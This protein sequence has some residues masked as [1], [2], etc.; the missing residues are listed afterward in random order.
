MDEQQIAIAELK[1]NMNAMCAEN[2][3]MES[4]IDVS[5]AQIRTDMERRDKETIQREK[6]NQRW[7]VGLVLACTAIVVGAVA[8]L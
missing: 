1:G 4:R 8:L 3:A 7:V 2:N 6:E 5:L